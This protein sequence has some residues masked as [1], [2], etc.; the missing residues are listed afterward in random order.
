MIQVIDVEESRM[1]TSTPIRIRLALAILCLA[2]FALQGCAKYEIRLVEPAEFAQTLRSE[3]IAFS[4][5]PIDY[6]ANDLKGRMGFRMLNPGDEPIALLGD[7]SYVVDPRGESHPLKNVTIAP[8]SFVAMSVPPIERVYRGGSG[9]GLGV[10]VG[11]FSDGGFVGGSVGHDLYDGPS[12][13]SD[14]YATVRV[15]PWETGEV[16]MHVTYQRGQETIE[17]DFVFTRQK[18]K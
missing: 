4:R 8:R 11:S 13:Y 2:S 7:K 10:G 15:W 9:F 18:V 14:L 1:N 12:S 5:P 17:H 6:R 3:E 16:R